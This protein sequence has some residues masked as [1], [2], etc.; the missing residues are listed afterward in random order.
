VLI[1]EA[2]FE[3]DMA[4]QARAKKHSTVGEALGVA[5]EMGAGLVVLTHFSQR[6]PKI[7]AMGDG[8]EKGEN[9]VL[10]FDG[11]RVRVRDAARFGVLKKGLEEIY[12]EEEVQRKE[13]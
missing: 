9:V 13:A 10:A 4:A 8:E 3:D 12:R 6:Y 7:A 5:R 2:T 11:A 1:H